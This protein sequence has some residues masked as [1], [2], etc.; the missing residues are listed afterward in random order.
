MLA[1]SPEPTSA[2]L[3]VQVSNVS[4]QAEYHSSRTKRVKKDERKLQHEGSNGTVIVLIGIR[5]SL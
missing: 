1:I 2:I 4:R 3:T 5:C